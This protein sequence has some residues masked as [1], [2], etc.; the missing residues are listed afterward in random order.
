M[1]FD[2]SEIQYKEYDYIDDSGMRTRCTDLDFLDQPASV[3]RNSIH[4]YPAM[5]HYLL[6]RSLIKEFSEEGSMIFDPFCGTGVS[7]LEGLKLGRNTIGSDI[8]PLAILISKVRCS[9][10]NDKEYETVRKLVHE[11]EDSRIWDELEIDTPDVKNIDYWYSQKA[12]EELSRIRFWITKKLDTELSSTTKRLL[13]IAFSHTSR[14]VSYVRKGEF[15][16]YRIPQERIAGFS[17]SLHIKEVFTHT[18]GHYSKILYENPI[19]ESSKC[20]LIYED[21]RDG[22]P[23]ED[24]SVDLILTSP[25]YGDSKTTV[26]YDEFSSFSLEWCNG[27]IRKALTLNDGVLIQN[28]N[29]LAN[30]LLG[31]GKDEEVVESPT[32]SKITEEIARVSEKRARDV[33]RFYSDLGGIIKSLSV[34]LKIGGHACFLVGNRTVSGIEVPMDLIVKEMFEET[35]MRLEKI[36]VRKIGNKRM[37]SKNSP[38]NVAGKTV[39]TMLYE[40]I[41]VMAK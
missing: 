1:L 11:I 41:V 21:I 25:P 30:K 14:V 32:L 33:R 20:K 9:N 36:L 39:N 23:I 15:K 6:V 24:G 16:R 34:K 18:L 22:I 7:L 12:I 13:V 31:S 29:D 27:L 2:R 38:S 4:M 37:P 19:P 10:V 28:K 3:E 26:A 35:G 8:N 40:Y 17:G 5:F